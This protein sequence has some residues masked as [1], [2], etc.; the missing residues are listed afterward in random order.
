MSLQKSTSHLIIYVYFKQFGRREVPMVFLENGKPGYVINQWIFNQVEQAAK[1]ARLTS[2]VGSICMLYDLCVARFGVGPLREA[3]QLCLVQNF[4]D[5]RVYGTD[6]YCIKSNCD[7]QYDYLHSLGLHWKPTLQS[8]VSINLKAI[9]IFDKW[10]ATYH[11]AAFLNPS[12]KQFMDKYEVYREWKIRE[13]W[14]PFQHLFDTKEHTKQTHEA[15]VPGTIGYEEEKKGGYRKEKAWPLHLFVKLVECCANPRDKMLVLLMGGASLR[16]AEPHHLLV[17]DIE[18]LNEWYEAKVRLEHPVIGRVEWHERGER[19][20]KTGT[21]KK[22]FE[23]CYKNE[24]LSEGHP[25]RNLMPRPLYGKR[26]QGLNAG[27]KGMTFSE[28]DS[29]SRWFGSFDEIGE[30][31]PLDAEGRDIQ[32]AVFQ[33]NYALLKGEADDRPYDVY[34]AWWLDPQIGQ[35]FYQCF[36]EYMDRY[37]YTNPFTGKPNPTNWPY[38]PWLFINIEQNSYGYPLSYTAVTNIWAR[39]KA[40]VFKSFP[41]GPEKDRVMMIVED[42]AWHSLR[43]FYGYYCAN[44][45]GLPVSIVQVLMHHANINS[46]HIYYGLAKST[47]KGAIIRAILKQRGMELEHVILPNTPRLKFPGHWTNDH[48]NEQ[49][50]QQLVH[51]G[52]MK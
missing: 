52:G 21:R 9:D 17:R 23:E 42:L 44:V 3:D 39:L 41:I 51:I 12:E 43:H 31:V 10:Q 20:I 50:L 7:P 26:N 15:V 40:R 24:F 36:Q 32:T 29:G 25:L 28:S 37:Y 35:Y 13:K 38:H 4:I 5:A 18:G 27:F 2:Y 46:T 45:L 8:N 33:G 14:D 11:G 1:P 49:L 16:R 22:F 19:E 47:V 6:E 34:H 30:D 48:V